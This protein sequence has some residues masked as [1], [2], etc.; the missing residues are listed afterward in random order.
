MTLVFPIETEIHGLNRNFAKAGKLVLIQFG[1]R[2]VALQARLSIRMRCAEAEKAARAVAAQTVAAHECAVR[3]GR[4]SLRPRSSAFER[5]RHTNEF[6]FDERPRER[7][8][9]KRQSDTARGDM[10]LGAACV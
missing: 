7:P 6:V 8:L 5:S 3:N 2:S 10:A 4:R 1:I 9:Y